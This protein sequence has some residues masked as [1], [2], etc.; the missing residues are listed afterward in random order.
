[1]LLMAVPTEISAKRSTGYSWRARRYMGAASRDFSQA[2]ASFAALTLQHLDAADYNADLPGLGIPSDFALLANPV[3]LGVGVRARNDTLCVLCL[4]VA[5]RWTGKLYTPLHSAPAM[6]VGAHGGD[7]L[8]DLMLKSMFSHPAQWGVRAMRSRCAAISGDGALCEGG[9]E[10]RHSS[11]AAA[12]RLWKMLYPDC[13]AL[14]SGGGDPSCGGVSPDDDPS[15]GGVSPHAAGRPPTC[16]VWDPFHRVDLAAWRAIR[17]VPLAAKVFDVARQLDYLFGQSEGVL[18]FRGVAEF[19][20]ERPHQMR[21]PG[22]TRKVGYLSGTPGALLEN[23]KVVMASLHAR[24]AW[25]QDG[26]RHYSLDHLLE[27]VFLRTNI[28]KDLE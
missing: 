11:T 17:Q 2:V 18:I 9:P 24:V 14:S 28:R 22:G 20:N 3:S 4:C 25:V 5:S 21:A 13:E 7:R 27:V 8:A 15:G 26:H 10:H 16:T 19:L 6:P 1:M 12:E 23:L